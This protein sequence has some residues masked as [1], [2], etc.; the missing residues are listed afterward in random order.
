MPLFFLQEEF[1]YA[2]DYKNS[3]HIKDSY[4]KCA[5]HE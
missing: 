1:I 2:L 5:R 3:L 4:N